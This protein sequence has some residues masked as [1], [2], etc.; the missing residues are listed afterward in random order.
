MVRPIVLDDNYL[1]RFPDAFSYA[2]ELD[3]EESITLDKLKSLRRV[4]SNRIGN[5]CGYLDYVLGYN[6]ITVHFDL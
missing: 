6:I 1:T 3:I 2:A 4:Y 5:F